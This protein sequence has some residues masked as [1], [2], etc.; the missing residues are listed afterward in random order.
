MLTQP[1]IATKKLD[2]QLQLIFLWIRFAFM[3][4][5]A[6]RTPFLL[7]IFFRTLEDKKYPIQ[8][9]IYFL[10]LFSLLAKFWW[11]EIKYESVQQP[12]KTVQYL[13]RTTSGIR[14]NWHDEDYSD[15]SVSNHVQIASHSI[16]FPGHTLNPLILT[17]KGVNWL[18]FHSHTDPGD[19]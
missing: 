5:F 17:D 6:T 9:R 1:Q 2:E 11:S 12:R 13:Y 3:S 14:W 10:F 15:H 19:H 8:R 7:T 16:L 18:P 4:T